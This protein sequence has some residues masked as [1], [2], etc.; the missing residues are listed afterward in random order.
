MSAIGQGEGIRPTGPAA[1]AVLAA[2]IG[3]VALGATAPL[4]LAVPR[5][6]QA[7]V[8][9]SGF[10]LPGGEHLGRFGGQQLVALLAWLGSWA[11]LHLRWRMRQ[12]S[13]TF[14]ALALVVSLVAGM[15]LSW[16]PVAGFIGSLLR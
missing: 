14:T 5:F 4:V 15:L 3:A 11:L 13:L 6:D 8:E 16:P 9:A 7:L 12:V 10:F 1:A 2:G